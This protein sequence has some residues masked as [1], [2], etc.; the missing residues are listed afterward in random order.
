MFDLIVVG[1]GPAGLSAACHA[2][3]NG[4]KVL[5]L[6]K[7]EVAN[8]IFDYQKGKHVMAEP[9]VLPLRSDLPFAAGTREDVLENWRAGIAGLGVNARYGA[10]VVAIERRAD[11]FRLS[12]KDGDAVAAERVARPCEHRAG[13][14]HADDERRRGPGRDGP[15]HPC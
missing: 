4:M 11:G 2:Q 5:V 13:R 10:E 8:T 15:G 3:R 9:P 1:A 7:G 14:V 6:E 12:L